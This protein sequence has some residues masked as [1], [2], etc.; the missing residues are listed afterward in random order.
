MEKKYKNEDYYSNHLS[1]KL[2]KMQ[3]TINADHP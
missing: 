2:E 3:N 1:S